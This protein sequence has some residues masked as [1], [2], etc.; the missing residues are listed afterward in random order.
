MTVGDLIDDL[1]KY[2]RNLNIVALYSGGKWYSPDIAEEEDAPR[3]I[4][5]RK[6]ILIGDAS[7]EQQAKEY[8]W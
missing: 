7:D 3:C 5:T 6:G 1:S 8:G 2:D 4:E